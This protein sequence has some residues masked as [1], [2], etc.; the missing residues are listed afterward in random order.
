M[1]PQRAATVSLC[2]GEPSGTFFRTGSGPGLPWSQGLGPSPRLRLWCGWAPSPVPSGSFVV[3]GSRI[4]GSGRFWITW[5]L[6]GDAP[7]SHRR[8]PPSTGPRAGWALAGQGPAQE[9]DA[10]SLLLLPGEGPGRGWGAQTSGVSGEGGPE[11]QRRASGGF[12][13]TRRRLWVIPVGSFWCGLGIAGAG[14]GECAGSLVTLELH[15]EKGEA[16]D[17]REESWASGRWPAGLHGRDQRAVSVGFPPHR[18]AAF[19]GTPPGSKE[20][21]GAGVPVGQE[22]PCLGVTGRS[23]RWRD[24]WQ[25]RA[26]LRA[27][28]GARGCVS[29]SGTDRAAW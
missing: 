26:G 4:S 18:L 28:A 17:S 14:T 20:G 12:P 11:A 16:P 24:G 27:D 23:C 6:W 2:E 1:R 22:Q 9:A 19:P 3:S 8:V 15:P 29:V 10:P 25:G 7:W 13:S 21:V 5:A